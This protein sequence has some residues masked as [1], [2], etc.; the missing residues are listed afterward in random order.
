M[1][2]KNTLQLVP[3]WTTCVLLD[4]FPLF[5]ERFW[6]KRLTRRRRGGRCAPPVDVKQ[7]EHPPSSSTATGCTRVH[8]LRRK[9]RACVRFLSH[10]HGLKR[11]YALPSR[12]E[13]GHL[14]SA[15]RS[16]F[17]Y[18]TEVQK[19]SFK[20]SQKLEKS[21]CRYCE[22]SIVERV[23]K[24]KE[25]RVRE[26]VCDG[27]HILKF[28]EQLGRN[29]ERGW[30]RGKYP[31]IPNGHACLGVTRREGGT[32]LAGT[33]VQNSVTVKAVV[34]AGKPRIVTLFG[35]RNGAV[36]HSLH[37]SLY[38]VLSRKGWLLVGSPTD[39]RVA[40]LN[41]GDY[42]SVD[43]QS[44]TDNI[45]AEYVRAIIRVLIDKA[46]GMTD[47]ESL[48]LRY[49]GDWYIDGL[50]V[51]TCQPMGSLMSFPMLCLF[52]KTVVDL[53]L[54]DLL[55][56]GKISFKEWTSHRC[57]INGDDLLTRDCVSAPGELLSRISYHASMVGPSVNPEKT[58]VDSTKGE[59]NSTL[60][61]N[62]VEEKKVNCGALCMGREEA[63]VV[64]FADR[65][66]LTVDGF[67]SCVRR[68]LSQLRNQDVKIVGTLEFRRFRAL[69]RDPITRSA[70]TSLPSRAPEA[71]NPFPVVS[72]PVGYDLTREE[73][74][75]L[76]R[77]RVDRLR[78][79]GYVPPQRAP[80]EKS[81]VAS[82]SV[83]RALKRKTTPEEDSVLLVLARG[84]EKRTKSVLA[85]QEPPLVEHVPFEHVC[86]D[87]SGRSR[88]IRAVCEIRELKRVSWLPVRE[89]Q[90][91]GDD[92]SL[93]L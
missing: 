87:C 77:E 75:V 42:I 7:N 54:N 65:S 22:S 15:I 51:R 44:A 30:N 90:V 3:L 85:Q 46:E 56:D 93:A 27:D 5:S 50:P 38:D 63:D 43:Y 58:M 26:V 70:L 14:R 8:S 13:C 92:E 49:I 45:K 47:E 60:F 84:W 10:E 39:E 37:H 1:W 59:I 23:N 24:W 9:A 6:S 62:A 31:Y 21:C 11:A 67:L 69:V 17:G 34:S 80:F 55:I 91:P 28:A 40:R 79:E 72:K 86:D 73:E 76:I 48:A 89:R 71:A 74:I 83:R 29:V 52:N 57:L 88:A 32:W 36:L 61:V 20:T 78:S 82:V 68:N 4:P 64:G 81:V 2:H 33:E 16:C 35:E 25:E 18:L 53:A 66:C 19:L 12:I 41:G